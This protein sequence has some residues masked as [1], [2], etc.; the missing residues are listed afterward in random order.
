MASQRFPRA[1]RLLRKR[2]FDHVFASPLR[3]SGIY[4]RGQVAPGAPDGARL[5][6]AIARRAV[7]GAV[8]RNRIRRIARETFRRLRAELGTRDYVI[9]AR[10]GIAGADNAQL[11]ADLEALLRRLA[12][13]N[14][15]PAPGTMPG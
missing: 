13:L 15:P 10:H 3:R 4:F 6:L 12:A 1:A 7:P 9:G 2:D 5:G 8:A 14:V 11:R